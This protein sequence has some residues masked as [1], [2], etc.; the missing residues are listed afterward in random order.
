MII[1]QKQKNT[2]LDKWKTR[3]LS[4]LFSIR[5]GGSPRPIDQFI[6]NREDGL[7]WLKIGDIEKG[8]KYINKTSSKIL[9]EGMPHSTFVKRGDFILSNSMSFGRP[10]ISNIETC[11]HDGWLTFQNI[12]TDILDRDFLYFLLLH[13]KTQNEFRIISAG[14][15]VQNLK[16]ETVAKISLLFPS[17][18]EQKRIVRVLETWD[19]GTERLKQKIESK[20][21]IKKGLMQEL[22]TGRKR[23][24]EFSGEWKE[25]RLDELCDFKKGSG[26]SKEKTDESGKNQCILYGEIYTTYKE[27][28]DEVKT[29]TNLEEG[30]TSRRGDILIPASTTTSHLDLATA[31]TV[32]QDGILLGGDINILRSKK[33]NLYN[34]VFLSFYLTHVKKHELA[35]F[36]QGVT[37]V[38]LYGAHFKKLKVKIPD[39]EEQQA[40]AQVLTIADNEIATLE[41]KLGMW[42]AQKKY[43]LNNLVTGHIRTPEDMVVNQT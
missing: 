16:R 27:Y 38:H 29:R 1:K 20:R 39:I 10:Y 32:F 28:I 43:L 22:L 33:D 23:L 5:R 26:L 42:Q 40:I 14:S 30:V 37:I 15:G 19:K 12:K 34:N 3:N 21:Q 36:A 31:T 41:K 11:I 25:Y 9:K 18:P 13:P 4:S 17:L 35:R 24:L 7:N 8:A 6:T 2:S